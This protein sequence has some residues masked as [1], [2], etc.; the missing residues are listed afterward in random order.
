VG[1][2]PVRILVTVDGQIVAGAQLLELSIARGVNIGY[3]NRGPLWSE[4]A[5]LDRLIAE[6]HRVARQR[7]WLYLAV[8]LPYLAFDAI[9]LLEKAGFLR[10]P[11]NLPPAVW[12]R[13]T[14][15]I[16]LTATEDLI[17]SRF[18]ASLRNRI[19]SGM[20]AGVGFAEGERTDLNTF[21][22]LM[23]ALCQ[24]RGVRPN[25]PGLPFLQAL[26]DEL[27]P[28][29]A[30]RLLLATYQGEAVGARILITLGPVAR[31][32]RVGSSDSPGRIDPI[33]V[34][35]WDSIKWAKQQ[36]FRVFD[37][38]GIDYPDASELL[39]GRPL[40]AP[41]KCGITAFKCG[42]GGRIQLLPGEFCLFPHALVRQLF[43]WGGHRVFGSRLIT[44]WASRLHQRS[45]GR[46]VR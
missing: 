3:L 20:R 44:N 40:S 10:R 31:D 7:R 1:W 27:V 5:P 26:W 43:A 15:T 39:S 46:V 12:A 32:W 41:F 18:Q 22:T 2:R 30:I 45:A 16:D 34:F 6:L 24:R 38:C 9:A 28:L 33:K 13:A 35:Y 29:N 8:S 14:T 23:C 25:V 37:F 21:W 19:R 42:F 11:E 36:G 4:G 17:F